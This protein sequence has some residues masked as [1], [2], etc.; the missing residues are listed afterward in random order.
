[1]DLLR[2]R[3]YL[4]VRRG[5]NE[6]RRAVE[7]RPDFAPAWAGLAEAAV[8]SG[9]RDPEIPIEFAERSVKL[10]SNCGL[11]QATLG[12][13][14]F[15]MKWEWERAG[16]HL[17]KGLTLQPDDP[18]I[19]YWYAQ[20][21]LIV[22]Q[23]AHA[24]KVI[25]AGLRSNP[26]A[27]NLYNLKAAAHYFGRDYEG[28]IGAADKALAA[29]L[30]IGWHWRSKAS[31]LLG[32]YP[33]ALDAL[34]YDWGASSA[35]SQEAIAQRAD[36]WRIT[37]HQFGRHRIL[38]DL[39]ESTSQGDAPKIH[40]EARARFFT[41]LG[42]HDRAIKSLELAVESRVFDVIYLG[43]DPI[44]DP[45]RARPEFQRLLAKIGLAR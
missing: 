15:V 2:Q 13:A 6:L 10:D 7:L 1:M 26:E 4:E 44:F 41:L 12:F 19:Q 38:R 45:L 43:V 17:Q 11:C 34:A 39:L 30:V 36:G 25:E 5:T 22:G 40:A 23:A 8:I 42:E 9:S 29:G 16:V 21:A 32:N 20:R 35:R 24:L 3:K 18:Q 27:L 33:S 37:F 14:R 28:A 31:F